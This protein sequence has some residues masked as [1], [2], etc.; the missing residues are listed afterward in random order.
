MNLFLASQYEMLTDSLISPPIPL[1]SKPSDQ[2]VHSSCCRT[3]IPQQRTQL[4]RI[5][6]Y[7]T[8]C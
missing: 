2:I 6:A 7:F 8:L 4:E 5:A 1:P 3:Q